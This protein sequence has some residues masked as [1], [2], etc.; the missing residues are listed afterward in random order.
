MQTQFIFAKLIEIDPAVGE[1][2]HFDHLA[3]SMMYPTG[4][5]PR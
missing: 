1:I 2:M 5:G 4:G 3:V